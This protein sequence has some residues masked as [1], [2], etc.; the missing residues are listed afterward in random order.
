MPVITLDVFLVGCNELGNRQVNALLRH[1]P[2]IGEPFGNAA[3]VLPT[4]G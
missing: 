3:A 1:L 4:A 2:V